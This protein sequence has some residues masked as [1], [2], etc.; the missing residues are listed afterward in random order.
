MGWSAKSGKRRRNPAR[1]AWKKL[2]ARGGKFAGAKFSSRDWRS[3]KPNDKIREMG[4]EGLRE[5]QAAE[6]SSGLLALERQEPPGAE[7][8]EAHPWWAIYEDGAL[9]PKS[10]PLVIMGFAAKGAPPPDW[11]AIALCAQE[12]FKNG[13]GVHRLMASF[14]EKKGSIEVRVKATPWKSRFKGLGRDEEDWGGSERAALWTI[15]TVLRTGSSRI[16]G[17]KIRLI[18]KFNLNGGRFDA[19]RAR[20]RQGQSAP[21]A[22]EEKFGAA[23]QKIWQAGG[24]RAHLGR[25]A[26]RVKEERAH[27]IIEAMKSAGALRAQV[28]P[29]LHADNPEAF[30]SWDGFEQMN[31]GRLDA[32]RAKWAI[33]SAAGPARQNSRMRPRM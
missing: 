16:D 31:V 20:K 27:A 6:Q 25:E 17:S 5:W 4:Q 7:M 28:C 13:C 14:G 33:D 30:Q 18:Q 11:P 22:W 24:A 29:G 3:S 2:G 12:R 19:R 26:N 8:D 15:C 9:R 23:G 21:R 32:L 1:E 10:E